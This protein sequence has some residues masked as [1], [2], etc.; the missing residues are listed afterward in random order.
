[1]VND[2]HA[3][4]QSPSWLQRWQLLI[5]RLTL[6]GTDEQLERQLLAPLVRPAKP[7]VLAFIN[8]HAMNSVVHD[9]VF[10]DSLLAADLVLR[11]GSGMSI[12]LKLVGK[13]PGLNLNGTDLIP[14]IVRGFAGQ[15]IALFGTCEPFL[16][17]AAARVQQELAPGAN[18]V[19]LDGFRVEGSYVE[20]AAQQRP[21]LILLG[22]GMPKQEAVA[23][24][25]RASLTHPCLIV[26]GGAILDFIGGKVER[27]PS[28]L[29]R[30]G[31]EWLSRLIREPR[32]L[33]RRYVLGNPAFLVRSLI[34]CR[35]AAGP[36]FGS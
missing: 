35:K 36:H 29:R 22:M 32:R 18:V 14:R 2:S 25:L 11:D 23:R 13:E 17:E 34:Y 27:A 30:L 28:W 5:E 3:S 9:A 31:M 33:F 19:C 24:A 20:L 8:A 12:L 1:M 4:A 6:I 21:A 7:T 15:R 16:A 10:A 26:C